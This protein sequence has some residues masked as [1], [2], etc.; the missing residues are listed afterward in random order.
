M[1]ESTLA[2][3]TQLLLQ[4]VHERDWK[5]FHNAKDMAISLV[6]EASELLELTQWKNGPELESSLRHNREPLADELA[7]VLF[8]VLEISDHYQI[9][10]GEAFR[11]KMKKNAAKYPI[12]KAKGK[13]TKYTEL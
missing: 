6:L 11:S 5:Q 3:L 12:E 9:D 1:A 13:S 7:D 10:L 4:F 8:W 2:E